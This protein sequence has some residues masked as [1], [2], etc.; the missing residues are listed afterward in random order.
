MALRGI[1]LDKDG[2]LIDFD[3]TWGP[4]AYEVMRALS[5]G[6]R[7][8]LEALM[9]VSHYVEDER[10]FLQTSPLIA[11][12]SAS[13]GPLWAQA[14]G[15]PPTEALYGEMDDLFRIWGLKTLAPIGEPEAT[16][17]ALARRGLALGIATNDAEA[18]ARAQ[19]TAMG[20]DPHLAY[21]A[22]YDSGFGSKPDPG[23]VLAFCAA[24]GLAPAEVALVGDTLHD[25][26]A[27]RA[28][29]VISVAVLTGPRG[30][31]ARAEVAPYADHVLDSIVDLPALADRLAAKAAPS[32]SPRA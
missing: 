20:L 28:A 30:L 15:R 31:D 8:R 10:R 17:R 18:S 7:G 27:A 23:M 11:G 6:D 5:R 9:A 14:L 4:A 25:L 26:H 2:T 3:R 1:L 29:G 13:Y 24:T 21:I 12:S 19:A 32:S 16:L 22:G